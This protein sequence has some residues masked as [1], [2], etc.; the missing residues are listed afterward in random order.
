MKQRPFAFPLERCDPFRTFEPA[1]DAV[2][3]DRLVVFCADVLQYCHGSNTDVTTSDVQQRQSKERW[4]ELKAAE[5]KWSEVLPTS[6]EPIYYRD[7]DPAMDE[8]FPEI[9]YLADCHVAGVQ[10]VELARILLS[11][12]DPNIPKLGPVHVRA[13]AQLS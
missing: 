9:W 7:P 1:E 6:F 2:W 4:E 8:V 13:L 3:A 11:V 10:H 12:Y 5:K